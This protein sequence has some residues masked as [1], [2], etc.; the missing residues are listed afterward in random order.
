MPL[1]EM[2]C[3]Y[4]APLNKI[5]LLSTIDKSI[6]QEGFCHSNPIRHVITNALLIDITPIYVCH[7]QTVDCVRIYAIAERPLQQDITCEDMFALLKK[8]E[9]K[10][11]I[12]RINNS[13][14]IT[15]ITDFEHEDNSEIRLHYTQPRSFPGNVA[16]RSIH[17]DLFADFII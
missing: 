12:A 16:W 13:N 7:I 9:F 11:G 3:F 10:F 4:G 2:A 17:W 15:D 5:E 1:F 6:W 8:G 14:T